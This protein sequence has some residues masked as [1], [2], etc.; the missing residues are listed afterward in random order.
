[1]IGKVKPRVKR[2]QPER[3]GDFNPASFL[4]FA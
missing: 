3:A 2:G 4:D 1:L